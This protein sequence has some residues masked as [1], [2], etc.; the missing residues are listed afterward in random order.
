M[1][2]IWTRGR[3]GV[4]NDPKNS[5]IIYGCSLSKVY[6]SFS[7][8]TIDGCQVDYQCFD[9][10]ARHHN[11][12]RFRKGVAMIMKDFQTVCSW[13]QFKNDVE[14]KYD[15]MLSMISNHLLHC[16]ANVVHSHVPSILVSQ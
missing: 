4:K 2:R 7:R 8:L 11:V 12:I 10:Q 1:N 3:E 5:D 16:T 13:V 9:F 15:L 6:F 14:W